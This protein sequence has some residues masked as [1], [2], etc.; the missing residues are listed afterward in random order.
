M[1]RNLPAGAMF[2]LLTQYRQVLLSD[3]IFEERGLDTESNLKNDDSVKE[4]LSCNKVPM[5][6]YVQGANQLLELT[7]GMTGRVLR[8][9]GDSNRG[10]SG[11]QGDASFIRPT[12]DVSEGPGKS[13]KYAAGERERKLFQSTRSGQGEGAVTVT[14]CSPESK[15]GGGGHSGHERPG[16]PGTWHSPLE[17]NAQGV[18][19]RAFGFR[20]ERPGG[21]E[22]A[23]TFS[24]FRRCFPKH[25]SDGSTL[26]PEW[27]STWTTEIRGAL[28]GLR[29]SLLSFLGPEPGMLLMSLPQTP[30][31][32]ESRHALSYPRRELEWRR[33][34][35]ALPPAS[36]LFA[37]SSKN[38]K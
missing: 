29:P 4:N 22:A 20:N 8:R 3:R 27:G 34:E 28:G 31:R 37:N 9:A 24:F 7:M 2:V 26:E 1:G 17:A 21:G 23:E 11:T 12:R 33:Q 10:Q 16:V 13:V 32:T 19:G 38:I 30:Q 25:R 6:Y 5:A 35:V 36:P 14:T 15:D 18:R